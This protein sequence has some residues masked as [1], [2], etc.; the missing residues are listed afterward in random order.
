MDTRFPGAPPDLTE[1]VPDT[2]L[3]TLGWALRE[4]WRWARARFEEWRRPPARILPFRPRSFGRSGRR[5]R[6]LP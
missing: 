1:P 5:L 2:V 3:G 4:T 6:H